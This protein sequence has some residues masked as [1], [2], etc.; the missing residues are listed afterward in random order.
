MIF[1]TKLKTPNDICSLLAS[2]P[3]IGLTGSLSSMKAIIASVHLEDSTSTVERGIANLLCIKVE[4]ETD[5]IP[6][7]EVQ[8]TVK[9]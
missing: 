9:K 4:L 2:F 5:P 6:S 1:F 7:I 8:T 3:G